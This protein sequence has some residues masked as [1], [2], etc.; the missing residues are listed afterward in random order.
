MRFLPLFLL[1]GCLPHT[2]H[3]ESALP[4]PKDARKAYIMSLGK[5]YMGIKFVEGNKDSCAQLYPE[6][7]KANNIAYMHWKKK[8][9]RFLAEFDTYYEQYIKSLAGNDSLKH[10]QYINIMNGKF[11]QQKTM[12]YADLKKMPA[13]TSKNTCKNYPQ[14]IESTL[15]PEYLYSKEVGF[16]RQQAVKGFETQ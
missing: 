3:A 6:Y 10:K 5:V 4:K 16:V 9:T 11:E 14:I 13:A 7:E 15:N 8:H 2:L 1:L 12:R